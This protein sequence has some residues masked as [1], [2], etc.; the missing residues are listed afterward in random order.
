LILAVQNGLVEASRLLLQHK[1]EIDGKDNKGRTPLDWALSNNN[2]G[3]LHLLLEYDASVNHHESEFGSTPLILAVQNGRFEASRLL[4]QHDA[5][6]NGKDNKGRTAL[7]WALSKSDVGA[8]HLLLEYGANVNHHESEFGL[9]PLI[10]AVLNGR[11]ET[12]R[13]LLQHNAEVDGKDNKGRTAL[14]RALSNNNVG[15]IRLLLEYGAIVNQHESE[16]GSTPLIQAVQTGHVDIVRL[17][18]QHNADV[19]AAD[20]EGDRALHWALYDG[21]LE[22]VR[23]L[24]ERGADVHALAGFN[25]TPL[26]IA[27]KDGYRDIAQLLLKYGARAEGDVPTIVSTP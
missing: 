19:E 20:L 27:L 16:F 7:D 14:Y 12:L 26:K 18:L 8:I 3:A 23:V 11:V 15:A 9:T 6:V 5:K 13:L 17:L 4:L 22:M 1:A 2:I 24:L 21:N 25:Q 10:L